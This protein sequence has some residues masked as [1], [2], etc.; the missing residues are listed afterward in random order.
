MFDWD[1]QMYFL[2]GVKYG[3]SKFE[4]DKNPLIPPHGRLCPRVSLMYF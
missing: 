4:G 3:V 1:D 2:E